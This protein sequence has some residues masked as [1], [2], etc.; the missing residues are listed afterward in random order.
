MKC[1]V[2]ILL[3]IG[4]G[5]AQADVYKWT[6]EHG[7]VHYSETAPAATKSERVMTNQQIQQ[8][9]KS[10]QAKPP[11]PV[12]TDS[13]IDE[14]LRQRASECQRF[15]NM[16]DDYLINLDKSALRSFDAMSL[17]LGYSMGFG[18]SDGTANLPGYSEIEA[19]IRQYCQD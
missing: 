17:G 13:G 15:K 2:A 1:V 19:G 14:E 11:R 3:M 5:C 7:E 9:E 16:R 8:I 6:D 12:D 4:G 10:D 18:G